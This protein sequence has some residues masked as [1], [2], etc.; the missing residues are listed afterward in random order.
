MRTSANADSD[1]DARHL[2]RRIGFDPGPLGDEPPESATMTVLIDRE[3]DRAAGRRQAATPPPDWVGEPVELPFAD[4]GL[5]EQARRELRRKWMRRYG[6]LQAWWLR[7][8][9]ET[10]APL[11][12]RMTLFWAG[13]FTSSYRNVRWGQLLYRQNAM[14]RR[15]ALGC[16]DQLLHEL[17]RDP[18]MLLYL[19]GQQNRKNE[20]NENFARELL[21]LFT[22]GEGHY[23]EA[24]IRDAARAFTGAK[25]SPPQGDVELKAR[26]HDDGRKTVLGKSGN[27]DGDDVVDIIL[28]QPR[29]AEFVVENLWRE[30]VSPQPDAGAV[31]ALAAGFRRDWRIAPLLKSLL[32]RPELLTQARQGTLVKS[33][34]EF[35]VGTARQLDLPTTPMSLA[36]AAGRMGQRLFD[37]PNVKG[38]PRGEDWITSEWLL[39]RRQF[40]LALAGDLPTPT[41]EVDDDGPGTK[42]PGMRKAA[43]RPMRRQGLAV[44]RRF[45]EVGEAL[46][47]RGPELELLAFAPVLPP[48]E[49]AKPPDR[50]QTWLLD[51][52]YQLK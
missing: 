34:V 21:E 35:V 32:G 50:L 3:V 13:R 20:P 40:V 52:V 48:V 8:M 6:E 28:G 43:K 41:D 26:Q 5:D 19:N 37:P 36:L 4:Q 7:E 18:A 14:L 1:A 23:T 46:P 33:P 11:A 42:E 15:H 51:P 39:Q 30:F 17:I 44:Q 24:D 29:A 38:W 27:F 31:K 49:G 16:Y 2:L 25:L 12:E 10:P 45:G 22:L 47:P 9:L